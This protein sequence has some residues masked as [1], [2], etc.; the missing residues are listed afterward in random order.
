M[1]HLKEVAEF[2][3]KKYGDDYFEALDVATCI[4]NSNSTIESDATKIHAV[5]CGEY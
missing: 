3:A 5:L 4:C 2:V 1:K